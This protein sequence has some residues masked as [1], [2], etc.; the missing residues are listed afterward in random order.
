MIHHIHFYAIDTDGNK[1]YNLY[2]VIF[3][4]RKD[5]IIMS[6]VINVTVWNE[7]VHEKSDEAAKALY[8][9][10]L[11]ATIKEFLDTDAEL[12]V[13]LAALH[14][15]DQ[16]LPDEVLDNTDVLLWWG[17]I[18]HGE[19]DDALV[20][21][22][23][24]R[25]YV[26]GMGFIALHSGHHS[27]PFR[28]IVGTTGNLMWGA[29]QKEIMWNIMPS[30]PIA[31][32]V[33]KYFILDEEELYCEPFQIPTPDEL[34]FTSWYEQG[35]VFRSGCVWRRGAGKV[36]YFQPGHETCPSYYNEYVQRII[37]NAVYWA[38]PN[39]FGFEMTDGCPMLTKKSFE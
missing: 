15:P 34:V 38:A 16:G 7:F 11:H 9:N 12:N 36:V 22:I 5:F 29:N 26:G 13:R 3:W 14:D 37:K 28:A 39:D 32:G 18:C 17:H 19:V 24:R 6:K 4:Q 10:G 20:E 27:K 23:R 30:H 8:P 21:R 1:V 31:A 25:V 2:G 35:Y 33:P